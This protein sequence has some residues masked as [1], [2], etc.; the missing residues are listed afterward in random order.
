[1][2][3]AVI[4]PLLGTLAVRLGAETGGLR[5]R[6]TI[7]LLLGAACS[8]AIALL[9]TRTGWIVTEY[10]NTAIMLAVILSGAALLLLACRLTRPNPAEPRCAEQTPA[11]Q[12]LAEK[13]PAEQSLAGQSLAEQ[14]C[15]TTASS[16][17]RRLAC[18]AA[19]LLAFSLVFYVLRGDLLYIREF[20]QNDESLLS[21]AALY[22]CLGWLAGA[23]I[24]ILTA[25]GLAVVCR[26]LN[27]PA[28]YR[29]LA[30]MLTIYLFC[31]LLSCLRVLY[32]RYLIPRPGWLGALLRAATNYADMI[33]MVL[34]ALALVAVV[35]ALLSHRRQASGQPDCPV[36]AAPNPAQLRRL[37]AARRKTRR[38]GTLVAACC[39]AS[40]LSFTLLLAWV[41]REEELAPSEE[42]AYSGEAACIPLSE[43]EDGHLHRFTHVAADG[44]E[45]RF[46]IIK[47]NEVAY[48]VGLDACN[49][50]GA[51]GYLERDEQVVCIK[52]DVVMNKQTIGFAGGCNP[53]PL[54][55][56]VRDGALYID[57]DVL[58]S[59]AQYF[60][61]SNTGSGNTAQMTG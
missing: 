24:C 31:G 16:L 41:N 9:K 54:E 48:G 22:R 15:T 12:D 10:W 51:T 35:L 56:A 53:I 60:N 33:T 40:V 45:V 18:W 49:I 61:G 59:G 7:A 23:G 34:L 47:K 27:T 5:R 52:C 37:R 36:A 17:R 44:T 11:G 58:E 14:S 25:A 57:K 8:I 1:M 29:I 46:I 20:A 26:Q 38:W 30:A 2:A 42:L 28:I 39:L 19:C 6:F 21:L 50:C 4:L 43:I 32:V 13:T 55:F 3:L